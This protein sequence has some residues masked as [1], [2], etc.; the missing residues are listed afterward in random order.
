MDDK[1]VEELID[2]LHTISNLCKSAKKLAEESQWNLLYTQ[3]EL[4]HVKSQFIIDD[5]CIAEIGKC[6]NCSAPIT[7][8]KTMCN[9]CYREY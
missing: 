4:L 3:L 9:D 6:V 2:H 5:Y 1:L 7:M 8:E